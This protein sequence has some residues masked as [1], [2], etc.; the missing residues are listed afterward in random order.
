MKKFIT[1]ILEAAVIVAM[2]FGFTAATVN[3][4][5]NEYEQNLRKEFELRYEHRFE[6]EGVDLL[7]P[8]F[9][10]SVRAQMPKE[11]RFEDWG[12]PEFDPYDGHC[13]ID[14]PEYQKGDYI[15]QK[16][17]ELYNSPM[18]SGCTVD[19][20]ECYNIVEAM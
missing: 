6:N 10:E 16:A 4:W 13:I 8:T 14:D 12:Y 1:T 9:I 19:F 2:I 15:M 5:D 20:E 11:F 18:E 7:S 17:M 3:A